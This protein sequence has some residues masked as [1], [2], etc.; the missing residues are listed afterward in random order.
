MR[1]FF[2]RTFTAEELATLTEPE[3]EALEVARSAEQMAEIDAL[4]E[5][6]AILNPEADLPMYVIVL[7]EAGADEVHR[8]VEPEK[9]AFEGDTPPEPE[10]IEQTIMMPR[11]TELYGYFNSLLT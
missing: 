3:L 1:L 2:D 4:R 11:G 6:Y 10:T 8:K 7:D 5:A 9:Y